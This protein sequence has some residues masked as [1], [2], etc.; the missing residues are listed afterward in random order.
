MLT[1]CACFLRIPCDVSW[2]PCLP[3]RSILA[4][5]HRKGVINLLLCLPPPTECS[6]VCSPRVSWWHTGPQTLGSSSWPCILFFF[7]AFCTWFPFCVIKQPAKCAI[8]LE[9]L[10]KCTVITINHLINSHRWTLLFAFTWKMPVGVSATAVEK[11][12]ESA[13]EWQGLG[14][15]NLNQRSRA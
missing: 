2:N 14:I 3:W 5:S 10:K 11:E 4:I 15:W 7:K 1:V 12:Q 9:Y 13:Q 6:C 8:Q